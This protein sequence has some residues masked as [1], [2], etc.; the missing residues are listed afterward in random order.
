MNQVDPSRTGPS[1]H[2]TTDEA[3]PVRLDSRDSPIHS[4]A[5]AGE[6]AP[7]VT[8]GTAHLPRTFPAE[9]PA[10]TEQQHQG[11]TRSS[12]VSMLQAQTDLPAGTGFGSVE[13]PGRPALHG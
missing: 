12:G 3:K 4:R 11:T 9:T 8:K 5:V 13:R 10:Q 7:T 1:H 6:G 2:P